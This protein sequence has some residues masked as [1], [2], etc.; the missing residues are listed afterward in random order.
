MQGHAFFIRKM[1][2]DI[3][4]KNDS[5]GAV[6]SGRTNI[7]IAKRSRVTSAIY[8]VG[9]SGCGSSSFMSW[10]LEEAS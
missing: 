9:A 10:D 4:G 7:I 5:T 1:A 2:W 3:D 8:F 6:A